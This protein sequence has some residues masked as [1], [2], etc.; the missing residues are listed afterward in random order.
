M[1]P[2]SALK[3]RGSSTSSWNRRSRF[4]ARPAILP[5]TGFTHVVLDLAKFKAKNK[6][7]GRN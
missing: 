3:P 1:G 4:Q 7:M 6:K 2:I 5:S